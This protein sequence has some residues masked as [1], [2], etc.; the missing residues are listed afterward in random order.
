MKS[1]PIDK[2]A[3]I[4]ALV[5]MAGAMTA[6][7]SLPQIPGLPQRA[8]AVPPPCP[9]VQLLADTTRVAQYLPGP[10]RDLTDI[11]FEI[12]VQDVRGNCET[13]DADTSGRRTVNVELNIVFRVD[14]G[15]AAHSGRAEFPYFIA[16]VDRAERILA[17]EI[18]PVA[19][20]FGPGINRSFF[21]DR[22]YQQIEMGPGQSGG[23]YSIFVGLQLSDG[24]LARNKNGG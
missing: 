15:P 11:T 19:V 1:S 13:S 9:D 17:K 22:V 21:E 18:F 8:V 4:A 2:A 20:T 7:A 3:C 10:G 12:K 23:D 6:C 5:V 24:E 14:R 16:V